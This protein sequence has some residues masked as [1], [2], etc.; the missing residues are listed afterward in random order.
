MMNISLPIPALVLLNIKLRD[1][2][3]HAKLI[4]HG[5]ED[6]RECRVAWDQVEDIQKAIHV[7]KER[8]KTA[9][10]NNIN[11]QCEIDELACREYD[12]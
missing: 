1:K 3:K 8:D 4:C 10:L 6:T 5:Y 11:L 9:I 12:V 7:K 2:I